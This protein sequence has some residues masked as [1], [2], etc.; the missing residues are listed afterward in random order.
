MFPLSDTRKLSGR[1]IITFVII[2]LNCYFFY[3]ELITTDLN[4]LIA[5]FALIPG[6]VYFNNP[7]TWLP[8]IT[9]Q[10]LHGGWF[11]LITN[12]W[13]L[14]VFGPNLEKIWG[15][16][17]FVIYYLL[18]GLGAGI[19]QIVFT[20]DPTIPVIG[21]SGAVAGLLGAY[22]IY[23]PGHRINTFIPLGFIPIFI[24]IPASIVL[25]YWF[26]LQVAG[27]LVP[28]NIASTNIAFFAHI[29][30]FMTGVILAAATR[31]RKGLEKYSL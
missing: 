31:P 22:L 6:H 15:P 2:V 25:I 26:G 11:H 19:M 17:R 7:F 14:A 18:A 3:R 16:T 27:G 8:L 10:F 13:F 21:A 12:M 4:T 5:Q 20:V 23:F 28:E 24:G 1:T 30:V 9:S 29:G